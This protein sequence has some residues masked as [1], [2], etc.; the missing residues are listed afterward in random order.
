MSTPRIKSA[1]TG[2]SFWQS[3]KML[4]SCTYNTVLHLVELKSVMKVLCTDVS[5]GTLNWRIRV[6]SLYVSSLQEMSE[7]KFIS[8]TSSWMRFVGGR[9]E[10]SVY[11]R[12]I[13]QNTEGWISGWKRGFDIC[14][15]AHC[16]EEWKSEEAGTS[17]PLETPAEICLSLGKHSLYGNILMQCVCVWFLAPLWVKI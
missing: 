10:K 13:Y 8:R 3:R 7:I 5:V 2:T 16:A 1:N 11:K 14:D 9:C 6:L 15:R 17:K 4:K 12:Q